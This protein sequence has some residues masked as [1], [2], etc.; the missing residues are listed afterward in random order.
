MY[1]LQETESSEY[2]PRTAMNVKEADGTLIFY[3]RESRGT[4]LTI[5]ICR[6]SRKPYWINPDCDAIRMFINEHEI[7]V[8]NIAGNRESVSPGIGERVRNLLV[9]AIGNAD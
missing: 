8:L 5:K 9:R 6:N 3:E 2:P 4:N 7:S 1:G